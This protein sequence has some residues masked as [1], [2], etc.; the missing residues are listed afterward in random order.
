MKKTILSFVASAMFLAQVI[1][2]QAAPLFPDVK[3]DHWAKDAVAALA[4]KGLLEGYPDGTFKGDRA[5][6]RWE[7]AMIVARLLAKMEQSNAT[8]ATKAD[9]DDLR[10]LVNSLKDELDALGVRV[11]NIE[12]Q[13][14]RLDRRVTE[15]ER[16]TFYGSVDAR[17]TISSFYNTGQVD[18]SYAGA[19]GIPANGVGSTNSAPY[20]NYNSAVGSAT[21][22][23]LTPARNGVV[24]VMD[25]RNGSPLVN[26]VGFTMSATLG[27]R[28][29]VT[30]E[31]DAGAEFVAFTSQ[32]NSILDAYQ[33]V[34]APYLTNA[35]QSNALGGN[36]FGG[37]SNSPFTRMVLNDFW[38]VHNPSQTKLTIGAFGEKNIDPMIYAGQA[39]P[40]VYG[41]RLLDSFGFNLNGKTD[42]GDAGV[43]RWE[44]LGT[45]LP[46][47][48]LYQSYLVGGDI[49][50]EFEGG[51]IKGNFARVNQAQ[52]A[53]N[54]TD[55]ALAGQTGYG[56]T[57]GSSYTNGIN[58][59]TGT[60]ATSTGYTPLQWVNPAGYFNTQVT[61]AGAGNTAD[62]RP[63]SGG[64]TTVDGLGG[65]FGPQGQ[66]MYGGSANFKVDLG[67]SGNQVYV[68]GN[69][70]HT[71]YRPNQNASYQ[72]GG[73]AYRGELGVNLLDGDLDI[74]G[75]YVNTDPN[76]DPFVLQY[77]PLLGTQ[78]VYR[79]P[80]LNYF[81]G[82]YSLH[83]TSVYTQ[84]RKGVRANI[85]FRFDDRR[86][87]IWLK[88][89]AMQQVQTSLYDVRVP[90]GVFGA[91]TPTNDVLGFSPGF[92]D[93]V[94]SGFA[95]PNVYGAGSANSF[96]SSLQPLENPR[97]VNN[98]WGGGLS[99]KL[100]NPR[101]K[102]E[103]GAEHH[104]WI[105]NSALSPEFGGSQNQV[106]LAINSFHGQLGFEASDRVTFRLGTD[107][108][109]I[110]GHYDPA[111]LYNSFAN[112]TGST[113]FQNLNSNQISPFVGFDYDMSANTQWNVDARYFTT[114]SNTNVPMSVAQ[115]SIGA[116]ANPFNYNG[117]LINTQFKVKF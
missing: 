77:S 88:G 39:N 4:A 115:D 68:A 38:I 8:F 30:D 104:E 19:G 116:A 44:V 83:D 84:N 58:L 15:L 56:S 108:T 111:G 113:T 74:S 53:N 2:A 16:I 13:V 5:A 37:S 31:I 112:L 26:G 35:F 99:Y 67:S 14:G 33:G 64:S 89:S 61:A 90:G 51:S 109:Q 105:R 12:E 107:Y 100:D 103:L 98:S 85:Q 59:G 24:P 87:L 42:I 9:L 10:K 29:R 36:T 81:S 75:Q 78:G 57:F 69:Y 3:D 18:N 63:I 23:G 21:G 32:G 91:T 6:T 73:N 54:S 27:V 47:Y 114:G 96:S 102:I 94:F 76:Y 45:E 40:N 97:G 106:N 52:P 22:Y 17:G 72:V 93:A 7:V 34:S 79:L 28:I 1:P 70:G 49:E 117:W 43:F 50:F 48:S 101:I 66:T 41:S 92:M 46:D 71:D 80:D 65:S 55:G 25:Y 110:R 62:K 95:S 86:G 82:L 20:V 60:S 11:T